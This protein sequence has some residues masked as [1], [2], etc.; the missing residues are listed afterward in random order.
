MKTL[1]LDISF[2][3]D[4]FTRHF[5]MT[6]ER[7]YFEDVGVRAETDMKMK[8]ALHGRFG[9]IGLGEAHP[10]PMA[11]L[12]YDDT[13]NVAL[14]FGG[15]LRVEG[16]LSWI[17]PGSLDVK[18]IDS[19][20]APNIATTWPHT[21]LLAQYD[22]AVRRFGPES[23]CPPVPHGVLEQALDLCGD[24][25]L[26]E[27]AANPERAGRLLDVLAETT[28]RVKEFWDRKCFGE[29]RN[30]LSLGGCSTT[31]LSS[32]MVAK[33]LAPRYERIA[34]H[35]GDAFL[36]CCGV[37]TQHLPTWARIED[38][39]YVRCGWGT[40]LTAAA[41]LL[42]HKHVKAAL[43]VV[44]AAELSPDELEKDVR[45]IL[46]TLSD[47]D[48]VS[49][50]LIHASQE[51]PDDNVRRLAQTVFDFADRNG[52]PLNDTATCTRKMS[53]R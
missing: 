51:T 6:F 1:E 47:V 25:F 30:G 41:R 3:R 14:M 20:K 19:L 21:R 28:I 46:N 13:L 11:Q 26:V 23:A 22:E 32:E 52:I 24:D 29:V 45:Y 2:S 50:L 17:E 49:V 9:D 34:S 8:R 43:D 39:R 16:G 15:E 7:D 40:D 18:A 36:C 31:M 5:G 38:V 44:R 37:T 10:Q 48:C 33:L 27:M 4:Y 53:S 12:G 42:P 35:F